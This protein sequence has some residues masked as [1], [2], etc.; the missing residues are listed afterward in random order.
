MF[1]PAFVARILNE[2]YWRSVTVR[3]FSNI[4]TPLTFTKTL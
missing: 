4:D 3:P 2:F 1:S